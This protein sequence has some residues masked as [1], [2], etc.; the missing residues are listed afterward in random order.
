MG[1]K[2]SLGFHLPGFH[3]AQTEQRVQ[4]E[5]QPPDGRWKT[6]GLLPARWT[7]EPGNQALPLQKGGGIQVEKR[8]PRHPR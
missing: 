4:P 5:P 3:P 2:V 1:L 6:E 8:L 7:R